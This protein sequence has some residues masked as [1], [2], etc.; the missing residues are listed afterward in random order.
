MRCWA[1]RY[2]LKQ[3]RIRNRKIERNWTKKTFVK[4][5]NLIG[6]STI[7]ILEY[8]HFDFAFFQWKL[9]WKAT[10]LMSK[11]TI[12][13]MTHYECCCI[14]FAS[15][16]LLLCWVSVCQS[17]VMLGAM[18]PNINLPQNFIFIFFCPILTNKIS[19][20]LS[21]VTVVRES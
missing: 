20:K 7:V 3:E 6:H 13:M 1:W 8:R 4:G 21:F 15:H 11:T 14:S 10:V 19:E 2:W 12:R 16:F 18:A 9:N 17:V 5:W